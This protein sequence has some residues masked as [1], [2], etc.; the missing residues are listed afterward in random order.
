MKHKLLIFITLLLS[1]NL[2]AQIDENYL[3][4]ESI[5]TK[6][7]TSQLIHQMILING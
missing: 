3:E 2:N 4:N 1:V 6:N 7:E 5:K